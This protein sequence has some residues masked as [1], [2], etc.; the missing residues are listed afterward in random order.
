MP[1]TYVREQEHSGSPPPK[2][3]IENAIVMCLLAL[4]LAAFA[5][6]G[7]ARWRHKPV[8]AAPPTG[9]PVVRGASSGLELWWW[10]VT[11]VRIVR[12]P[13]PTQKAKPGEP[14]PPPAFKIAESGESIEHVLAPYLSRPV[15]L[16]SELK[17]RWRASGLRAVCVPVQDLESLETSLRLTGPVQRQWLG[18]LSAWTDVIRGPQFDSS[19]IV[20]LGQQ[21][22]ELSPGRLR[23]MARCWTYPIVAAAGSPGAALR[24]ELVPQFEPAI[25][26]HSRL[27]D[28]ALGHTGQEHQGRMFEELQAGL[29]IDTRLG[30]P[31]AILIIPDR[32]DSDWTKPTDPDLGSGQDGDSGPN[33]ELPPTLGETML[34]VPAAKESPRARAVIILIPRL[35]ERFELLGR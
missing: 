23:M 24:I 8:A 20:M 4:F 35:P 27:Q 10:V 21:P 31:D 12:A 9:S 34:A 14:P 28:A 30:Q 5:L 6:P 11:D 26:E 1:V 33:P 7:C 32:P 18:E 16:S 22:E 19:R 25:S 15:P 3:L 2:A 17:E 13:G 29:S